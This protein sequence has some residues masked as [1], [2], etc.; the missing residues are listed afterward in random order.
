MVRSS[1]F[2]CQQGVVGSGASG[3]FS[4]FPVNIKLIVS[5][6]FITL[7][8]CVGSGACGYFSL[9]PVNIK[10]IVSQNFITLNK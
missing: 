1:F 6:N 9:F 10:L 8:K 7:K 4:L 3:Y 5:Q 2:N